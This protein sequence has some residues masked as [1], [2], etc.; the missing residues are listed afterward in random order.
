MCRVGASGMHVRVCACVFVYMLCGCVCVYACVCVCLAECV[1]MCVKHA[2]AY[3]DACVLQV[4]P[5]CM[6]TIAQQYFPP[7]TGVSQ[8]GS[9]SDPRLVP[10]GSSISLSNHRV[11]NDIKRS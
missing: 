4:L 8:N 6:L 1:C 3:E 11:H 9:V 7:R 2:C 5:G 10:E